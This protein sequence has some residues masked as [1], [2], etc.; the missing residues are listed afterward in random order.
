MA[1]ITTHSQPCQSIAL[2]VYFC[3]SLHGPSPSS[4]PATMP[5]SRTVPTTGWTMPL[6]GSLETTAAKNALSHIELTVSWYAINVFPNNHHKPVFLWHP[7][8]VDGN[9]HPHRPDCPN[10]TASPSLVADTNRQYASHD[11]VR[12]ISAFFLIPKRFNANPN[13]INTHWKIL[14]P[15]T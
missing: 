4:A 5:E 9:F 12:Y 10:P 7:S 3:E 6:Y 2:F 11:S 15:F 1:K 13:T 8:H 14:C